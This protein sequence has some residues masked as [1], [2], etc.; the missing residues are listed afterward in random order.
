MLKQRLQ[1]HADVWIHT[2]MDL[3]VANVQ[4]K[5][6]MQ[7]ACVELGVA[8][9]HLRVIT[10]NCCLILQLSNLDVWIQTS[11]YDYKQWQSEFKPEI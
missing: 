3:P 11:A 2:L 9:G 8:Y 5:R 4:R 7:H 1:S 10:N 6:C